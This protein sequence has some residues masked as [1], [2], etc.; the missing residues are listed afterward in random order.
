[1]T[2]CVYKSILSR[3]FRFGLVLEHCEDGEIN[4]SLVRPDEIVEELFFSSED[5]SDGCGFVLVC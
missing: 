5:T 4:H 2:V 3:I 1:M